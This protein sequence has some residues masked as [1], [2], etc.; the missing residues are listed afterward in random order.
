MFSEAFWADWSRYFNGIIGPSV[1]STL[2]ML[3]ATM[4][5]AFIF[6]FSLAVALIMTRPDGLKPN[7]GIY[8]ALYF[9]VNMIRSFPIII[10]IVAIS[11]ITRS[12]VGTT[13]GEKAAILP[14]T[15]AATPFLARI[16][17]NAFVQVDRQLIEAARRQ[18][19]HDRRR[20]RNRA[21]IGCQPIGDVS[22][23]HGLSSKGHSVVGRAAP[24]GATQRHLGIGHHARDA[25]LVDDP[26]DLSE[27]R[28]PGHDVSDRASAGAVCAKRLAASRPPDDQGRVDRIDRRTVALKRKD[29]KGVKA[30]KAVPGQYVTSRPLEVVQIAHTEVDVFLVDETTRKTMDKRPWHCHI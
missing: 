28:A 26:R 9:I 10:L 21:G 8:N 3:T 20:R 16:F 30:T 12:V 25:D 17:E 2:R 24:A 14:L 23:D 15:I 11:P 1:F 7:R 4:I 6:G 19:A 13:I 5:L 18:E 29:A 22:F 27:A